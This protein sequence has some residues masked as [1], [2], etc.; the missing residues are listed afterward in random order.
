MP[1]NNSKESFYSMN[2]VV[3]TEMSAEWYNLGKRTATTKL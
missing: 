1:I 2:P 3:D